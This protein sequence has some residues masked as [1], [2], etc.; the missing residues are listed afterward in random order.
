M[1]AEANRLERFM[2]DDDELDHAIALG[3]VDSRCEL[4][5]HYLGNNVL[6]K[7]E[8]VCKAYQK[9]KTI[10]DRIWDDFAGHE[11]VQSDQIGDFLFGLS[12]KKIKDI[13]S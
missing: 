1:I 2:V 5:V 13:I 6:T 9:G 7:G 8:R 4:C 11:K 3:Q 10:P 12:Q